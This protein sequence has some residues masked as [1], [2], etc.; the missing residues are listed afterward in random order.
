MKNPIRILQEEHHLL[1]QAIETGSDIQ[2]VNDNIVFYNLMRD[3]IIFIRNYTEIYHHPK[4]ET[5][6]YPLLQNRS[7]NM[8]EEF[9]HEICD[10][11]EDFKSLI[12]EI[13]N[14]YVMY[15]FKQLRKAMITYLELLKEHIKREN[16]II[17]SVADKFLTETEKENIYN[18]FEKIDKSNGEKEELKKA[19]YKINM[20][21]IN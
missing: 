14:H 21:I 4:E 8:S 11:H 2:K 7:E 3:F 18:L 15:D 9:I 19:L 17:L 16:K 5:I 10:N 12:A 20:Q 6:L 1:L 13:E